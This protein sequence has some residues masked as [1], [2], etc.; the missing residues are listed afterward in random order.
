ME[1]ISDR[2]EENVAFFRRHLRVGE[3][4]DVVERRLA[5]G[6][7]E[8]TLFYID[9]FIKDGVMLRLMQGFCG[10]KGLYRGEGDACRRFVAHDTPYV[11]V[12]VTSD[13][14]KL[15]LMILSGAAI[16]FGSTFGGEAVI[17][18]ARTYPARQ[19]QEP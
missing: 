16:L 4:F 14:E 10:M 17:I 2:Y 6:E 3:N 1:K 13:K 19:T 5:V 15:S 18:D 7:D 8:L 12:E 11:E 9:G